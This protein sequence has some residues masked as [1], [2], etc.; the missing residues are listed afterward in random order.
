MVAQDGEDP[1]LGQEL[2]GKYRVVARLGA[3]GFGTVYSALNLALGTEV[4]VKVGRGREADAR[5][6]REA[7]AAARLRGPH[8]VRVYDVG[9]L[10][11]GAPFIVM[12]LLP[13]RS[14][15][16]RLATGGPL[17]I[18][19]AAHWLGQV[20]AALHE[21]HAEGLVH[22][23]LKPSN[24]FVVEGPTLEAHLKLLDFGLVKSVETPQGDTTQSG[25]LLGSPQYMSPEQVRGVRVDSSSDIWSL[26][27]VLYECL[28]GKLP[29]QRDTA[30]G[31]LVAI[32][33]EPPRPLAEVAPGLPDAVH[34]VV[35]RCLRKAPHERFESAR[36][37]ASALAPL[38]T[39]ALGAPASFAPPRTATEDTSEVTWDTR[40]L[41]ITRRDA[42]AHGTRPARGR[43]LRGQRRALVLLLLGASG[44]L[45][46][47][48]VGGRLSPRLPEADP[49]ETATP[50][51]PTLA[52]RESPGRAVD[53][54]QP[55]APPRPIGVALPSARRR[56]TP[57]PTASASERTP[58]PTRKRPAAET[59][60]PAPASGLPSSRLV[61]DPNF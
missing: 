27:V 9:Q 44:A 46:V 26:G 22:R 17:P 54:S 3:G 48:W 55:A 56:G 53:R 32:A 51:A 33:S 40:G 31:T 21:A 20:C 37:L 39:V 4:A 60:G 49:P 14:L 58:S 29:F 28:S 36:A 38:G 25:Q 42:L 1:L 8:T 47:Y 43:S 35:S 5:M 12:E 16:E 30:T 59:T 10:P 6:L 13:G 15:K 19:L 2:A 23:D 7:R 57:A 41:A 34:E 18:G 52:P 11:G 24:L 50:A 45:L 61:V